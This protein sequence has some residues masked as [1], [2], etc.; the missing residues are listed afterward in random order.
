MQEEW[1]DIEGY[2]NYMISNMGRVKS[3]NYKHTGIEKILK[4]SVDKRG[5]LVICLYKNSVKKRNFK[6]HRLVAKAFIP[7][8]NNLPQVNHKDENKQNNCLKN[9]EWCDQKYNNNFGTRKERVAEKTSKPVLKIDP[10]SNEIVAEFPSINEV[11]RQLGFYHSHIS[12]CCKG[13]LKSAYSFKWQY[14]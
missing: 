14:K 6:I 2:Q 7:N 12:N 8:P 1:R 13:K 9:L 4:P 11:Q 10:I 3:L 5:Y